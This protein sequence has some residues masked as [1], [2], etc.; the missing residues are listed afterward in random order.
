MAE[1]I[2]NVV[3]DKNYNYNTHYL[4]HDAKVTEYTTGETRYDTAIKLIN[5]NVVVLEKSSIADGINAV[6]TIFSSCHFDETNCSGGFSHLSQYSRSW[7]KTNGQF[8]DKPN[9]NQHSN[10]ADAFRYFAMACNRDTINL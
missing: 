7:D 10:S 5:G 9:H 6:R 1:I 4:P 2:N 8:R 3:N